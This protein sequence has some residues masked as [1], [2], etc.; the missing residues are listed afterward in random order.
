MLVTNFPTQKDNIV[1]LTRPSSLT[2]VLL[3]EAAKIL[4]SQTKQVITNAQKKASKPITKNQR[5]NPTQRFSSK[6]YRRR[7][8]SYRARS[9]RYKQRKNYNRSR[10]IYSRWRYY[11]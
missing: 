10:P 9:S 3:D 2:D 11:R 6:Y 7:I 1:P 8:R 4:I 5:R